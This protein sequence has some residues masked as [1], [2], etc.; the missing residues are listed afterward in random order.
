[1]RKLIL[2]IALVAVLAVTV[3][4]AASASQYRGRYQLQLS[5][6]QQLIKR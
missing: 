1:M 6:A 2:L 3:A 4:Q 5:Q